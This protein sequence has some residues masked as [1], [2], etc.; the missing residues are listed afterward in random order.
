MART[1]P[2]SLRERGNEGVRGPSNSVPMDRY[3]AP[4]TISAAAV[5]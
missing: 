1:V 2:L 5:S 3:C 4:Q